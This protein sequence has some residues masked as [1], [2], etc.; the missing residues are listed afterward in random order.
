MKTTFNNSDFYKFT[1]DSV[2]Q[3]I[4]QNQFT[5]SDQVENYLNDEANFYAKKATDEVLIQIL[6]NN[7]TEINE[8]Y[9]FIETKEDLA[10]CALNLWM[11]ENEMY[12]DARDYFFAKHSNN[13]YIA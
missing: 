5:L 9:G 13:P 4:D 3:M 8:V 11:N 2:Y 10:F 6:P 7:L 12:K 1:M